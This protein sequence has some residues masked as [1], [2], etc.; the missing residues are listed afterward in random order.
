MKD[1]FEPTFQ[2]LDA[3]YR[4]LIYKLAHSNLF[5]HNNF[6]RQNSCGLLFETTV[7]SMCLTVHLWTGLQLSA[8]VFLSMA[9]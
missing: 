3:E 8:I 6:C 7:V 4:R 2:L 5:M 9:H 1:N